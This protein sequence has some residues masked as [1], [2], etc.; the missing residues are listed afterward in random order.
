MLRS[1]WLAAALAL[2]G[3]TA[4]QAAHI[5]APQVLAAADASASVFAPGDWAEITPEPT[6]IDGRSVTA[7]CSNAP[8]GDPAFRFWFRRGGA[9]GL[10]IFFDGGGACWDDFTCSVPWLATGRADDG[11]YKAEILAGDDPR[12]FGGLFEFGDARNPVRDWS[13]VFVPY[14]TGDVHLGENTQTYRNVDSGEPFDIRHRG[15][16]NFSVVLDWVERNMAAPERLLVAGSSAG[17]YGAVGHYH[18]IREAFPRADAIMFA[19][20]GQGVATAEFSA[21]TAARWGYRAPRALRDGDTVSRLASLY[22]RDRFAQFTTA[23]DRT[24]S[25]FYALMGVENACA[26]W[27]A[28]MRAELSQ[29]QRAPN[30]RSYVAAGQ[31]HTILRSPAFYT[32]TSGG[33][34]FL[35]WFKALL[36]GAAP[37]NLACVNCDRPPATC[38]F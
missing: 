2:T 14:C 37:Q 4:P 19:D 35:D 21:A 18:R 1:I 20:A 33:G 26:A 12:R 22:P 9:D 38:G 32:E 6:R 36:D 25:A 16:D 27:S 30:F 10:V 17:A 8:G 34:L 31:A 11:F 3:C 24:Q 5:A 28:Q 15:A 23:H 7:T 13:F 29:R